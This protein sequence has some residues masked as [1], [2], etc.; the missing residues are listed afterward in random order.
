VRQAFPSNLKTI[1]ALLNEAPKHAGLLYA[2]ASG[3]TQYAFGFVQQ[4]ADRVETTDVSAATGLRDRAVKLYQRGRDY[5]LRGL[6]VRHPG[7]REGLRRDLEETLRPLQKRD[8]PLLY[9]TALS[10]AAA[11]ALA[12]SDSSLS[13]DQDLTEAMMTRALDLDEAFGLGSLHDFFIVR[14][15]SRSAVGGSVAKAREH[16]K[17]ALDLAQ[18]RRAWPYVFFAESASLAAQD[19]K[20]FEDMLHQALAVDPGRDPE[21]RLSNLLAQSRARWLLARADELFVE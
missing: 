10:W 7:F 20:E 21:Q 15:A 16:L 1:E 5:G 9:W 2:A 3:F 12:K 14:E 6:E 17:R 11:M 18:G 8:V 19:R 4:D 13:A